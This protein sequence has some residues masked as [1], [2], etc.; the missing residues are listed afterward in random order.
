[1]KRALHGAL[2]AAVALAAL[3]L[4]D[5]LGA[6]GWHRPAGYAALAAVMLRLTWGMARRP[7]LRVRGASAIARIACVASLALTGWLY[8]T[9]MFW[10]SEAVEALHLAFAWALLALVAWHVVAVLIDRVLRR[11]RSTPRA[12]R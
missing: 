11:K 7:T 10:G 3:S 4:L 12:T 5:A 2:V 1:M 6:S 9:D 8:T